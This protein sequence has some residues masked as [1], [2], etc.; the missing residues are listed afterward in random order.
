MKHSKSVICKIACKN[1]YYR[2]LYSSLVF[3]S[4]I[5]IILT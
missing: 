2:Y 1:A 4:L 5:L 3:L